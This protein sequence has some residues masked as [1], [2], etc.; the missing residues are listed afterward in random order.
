[1]QT[2]GGGLQGDRG[3]SADDRHR[4][5]DEG[6]LGV[7]WGDV[8][9]SVLRAAKR[10]ER[11]SED[12]LDLSQE[13]AIALFSK[14][15]EGKLPEEASN[16]DAFIWRV[17]RN[18]YVDRARRQARAPVAMSADGLEHAMRRLAGSSLGDQMYVFDAF[19]DLTPDER[20]LLFALTE[21][22]KMHEIAELLGL[23][24]STVRQRASRL[25]AKLKT[26]IL[27]EPES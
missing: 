12:A 5:M 11:N 8:I 3:V 4:T 20:Q 13:V 17:V 25:R 22:M 2:D 7:S 9:E 14:A 21:G 16:L 15:L 6:V 18:K 27:E 10:L 24:P 23:E 19:A 1:M 26:R